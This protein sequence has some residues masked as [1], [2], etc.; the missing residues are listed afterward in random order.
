MASPGIQHCA[1]CID[2]LSFPTAGEQQVPL[3]KFPHTAQ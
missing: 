1:N 2:T 3:S